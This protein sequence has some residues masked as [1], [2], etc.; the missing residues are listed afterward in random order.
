MCG[1]LNK[2]S[3]SMF[4]SQRVIRLPAGSVTLVGN[5]IHWSLGRSFCHPLELLNKSALCEILLR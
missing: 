2:M 4:F 5:V 1:E 3:P